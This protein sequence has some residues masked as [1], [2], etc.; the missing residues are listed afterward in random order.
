MI[1]TVVSDAHDYA[2]KYLD[3]DLRPLKSVFRWVDAMRGELDKPINEINVRVLRAT[4][5]IGAISVKNYDYTPLDKSIGAIHEF[6][7]YN[8]RSYKKLRILG[9]DF[10]KGDPI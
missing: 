1:D 9:D 5:D 6:F 10:D 7:Y 3:G 8:M 4:Q 2:E